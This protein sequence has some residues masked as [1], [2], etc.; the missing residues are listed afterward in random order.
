MT[1]KPAVSN[2]D[3]HQDYKD[4]GVKKRESKSLCHRRLEGLL[5]LHANNL[6]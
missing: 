4:D 3:L 1:H 6:L 2:P 5:G